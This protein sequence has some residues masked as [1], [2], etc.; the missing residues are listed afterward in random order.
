MNEI[1]KSIPQIKQKDKVIFCRTNSLA[2]IIVTTDNIKWK[3]IERV[4]PDS[5]GKWKVSDL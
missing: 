3:V 5:C 2:Y 1:I 4:G